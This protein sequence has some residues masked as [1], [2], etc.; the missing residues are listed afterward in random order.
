M[1]MEN[2]KMHMSLIKMLVIFVKMYNTKGDNH[3]IYK[4]SLYVMHE[5]LMWILKS[6]THIIWNYIC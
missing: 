5:I 2:E 6:D 3:L 1:S 4:K